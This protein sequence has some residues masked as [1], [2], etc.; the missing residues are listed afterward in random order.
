MYSPMIEPARNVGNQA[1]TTPGTPATP[2]TIAGPGQRPPIPHP[3]PN[4]EA[5]KISF[6]SITLLEGIKNFPFEL[7]SCRKYGFSTNI[8]FS[9]KVRVMR[10]DYFVKVIV[11]TDIS[12]L[13]ID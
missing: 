4:N 3:I 5:P 9:H 12:H 10:K 13:F 2:R 11:I 1:K 6:L 8:A 7:H